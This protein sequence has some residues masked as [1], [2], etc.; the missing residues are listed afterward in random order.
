MT[1][2]IISKHC[3][4]LYVTYVS[5]RFDETSSYGSRSGFTSSV[6]MKLALHLACSR[7]MHYIVLATVHCVYDEH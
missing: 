6:G 2:V 5:I 1:R 4:N 7:A 3:I